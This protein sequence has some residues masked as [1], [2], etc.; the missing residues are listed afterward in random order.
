MVQENIMSIVS[1]AFGKRLRTLREERGWSQQRLAK[2]LDMGIAQIHRY[3]HGMSQPPLEVLRKL[4]TIFR[5]STDE[6]VFDRGGAGA[7]AEFLK[8][9]LLLKFERV[10]QLPDDDQQAVRYLL[11]AI[12]ARSELQALAVKQAQSAQQKTK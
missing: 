5:V 2:E 8:G 12:I 6:L 1:A 3:E 7:A 4:A 9:D 11:D 10:S